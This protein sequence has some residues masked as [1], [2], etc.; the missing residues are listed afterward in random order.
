M[1]SAPRHIFAANEKGFMIR[2]MV[3]ASR[4]GASSPPTPLIAWQATQP[5]G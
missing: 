3:A 5:C 2:G 4:G 1:I